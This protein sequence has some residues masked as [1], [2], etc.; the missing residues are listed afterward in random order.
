MSPEA[1]FL[2]MVAAFLAGGALV[3]VVDCLA[4]GRPPSETEAGD[5]RRR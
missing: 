4:G 1:V 2:L 3:H 5:R